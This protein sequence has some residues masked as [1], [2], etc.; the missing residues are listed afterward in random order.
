MNGFSDGLNLL[1]FHSY[2]HARDVEIGRKIIELEHFE[3]IYTS[4]HWLVRIY[5]VKNEK[6]RH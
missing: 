1:L 5:R 3:E 4:E 6:N 2:D